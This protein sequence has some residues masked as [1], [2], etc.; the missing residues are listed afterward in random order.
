MEVTSVYTGIQWTFKH[1]SRSG[2]GMEGT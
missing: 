1:R 2:G